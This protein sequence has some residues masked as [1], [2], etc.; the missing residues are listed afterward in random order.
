MFSRYP[1]ELRTSGR[2]IWEVGVSQV[3]PSNCFRCLEKLV[4]HSIFDTIK[5]FIVDDVKLAEYPITVLN[6]RM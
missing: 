3:K 5:S 2:K 6:E 1:A 4:F